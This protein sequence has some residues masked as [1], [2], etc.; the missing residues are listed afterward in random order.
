MFYTMKI[1]HICHVI[2]RLDKGGSAENTLLTVLGNHSHGHT[3]T[4]LCGVS[5]NP[6]SENENL[7]QK[8]GVTIIRFPFLVRDISP[9]KDAITTLQLILFF[10]RHR[11]LDIVHTHTSKAGILA[12][13]AG[14]L[15]GIRNIVHTPH[16]HIFYGYFSPFKTNLFICMERFVTHRSAALITLT[17]KERDDYIERHIGSEDTIFPIFSG[18]HME[19]FI[20]GDSDRKGVRKELKLPMKNYCAVTVARLVSV[21][22]HDLIISA[23]ELLRD[24]IPEIKFVFIGDGDLREHLERRIHLDN[25]TEHFIFTGWRNDIPRLLK[26]F[27]LFIMCSHNEGMGRAFV[28]AQASGLSVIG[29][30][31]GGVPEVVRETVT[32]YLVPPN[33]V[34][35]LAEKIQLMYSKR[36]HRK[37]IS[38]QCRQWVFPQFSSEVMVD[39]IES[40]YSKIVQE[41]RSSK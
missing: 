38:Q 6:P 1:L 35:A 37:I 13:L 26:A 18:I 33:D 9:W 8:K 4:L 36:K 15:T 5:N 32:G 7:A 24:T 23:A 21:K 20:H 11:H 12:R 17:H 10:L 3:V 16:G 14:I 28:E 19:P 25:L 2:T 30:R 22:N 41:N 27:D 31:V 39:A 29:S 34:S 40:V